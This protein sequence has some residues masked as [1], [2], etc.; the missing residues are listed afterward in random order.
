MKKFFFGSGE[1]ISLRIAFWN[2]CSSVLYSLQSAILLLA[3]TRI[4]GLREAGVFTIIYTVTQTFAS[5]G[6]YSMRSFQVSDAKGQFSFETYYSSRI[7]TCVAMVMCD[8]CYCLIRGLSVIQCVIVFMFG[9]YRVVDSAEDVFHGEIQKKG[10]LDVVAMEMTLRITFSTIVFCVTFWIMKS[11]LFASIGLALSSIVFG[12]AVNKYILTQFEEIKGK[13]TRENVFKLLVDC[14]PIFVGA[15]L[16]NY[17]VNAPKYA[18][19]N[20]LAEE[21]QTIFN[22]LFMPIFVINILSSFIFK[23]LIGNMGVYWNEHKKIMLF[24]LII[25]QVV[26]IIGMTIGIIL[27]GFLCGCQILSIVYG[28]DLMRYRLLFCMLLFFGG[29]AA[30]DS[31]FTVVITVMRK[32]NFI[33]FAYLIAFIISLFVM[34]PLV[35]RYSLV[36]AG[37]GYGMVM[38]IILLI[39]CFVIIHGFVSGAMKNDTNIKNIS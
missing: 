26:I 19:N 24:K 28:V 4:G 20:A 13:F 35:R 23:P 14:F 12:Y 21:Y 33:I 38:G 31:F 6:S 10:R 2:M 11:L 37:F 27:A 7:V 9:L 30:L 1:N 29:I 3:V 39:F 17:L 36:G 16:Y 32:Q 34:V 5:L 8:M 15:I 18:I 25:R 22:I